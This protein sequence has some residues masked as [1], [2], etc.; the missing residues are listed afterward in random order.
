M[1]VK[2]MTPGQLTSGDIAVLGVPFDEYSSFMKGPANAPHKIR[3]A[4]HSNSSNTST[5]NEIDL[6]VE[7]QLKNLGDLEIRDYIRDI[8]TPVKAIP[9]GLSCL[10]GSAPHRLHD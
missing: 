4:F 2:A 9:Y 5:E 8:E 10:R 3:E 1:N 6:N 7:P